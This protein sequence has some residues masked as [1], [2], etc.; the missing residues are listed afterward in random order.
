VAVDVIVVWVGVFRMDK[1]AV[2]FVYVVGVQ[3]GNVAVVVCPDVASVGFAG[4][5]SR[6]ARRA[7]R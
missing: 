5:L 2:V 1:G 7:S 3:A 4:V 6:C